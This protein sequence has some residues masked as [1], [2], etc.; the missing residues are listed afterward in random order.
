MFLSYRNFRLFITADDR[1]E[2]TMKVLA[3]GNKRRSAP[4]GG[5][6]GFPEDYR[7][8]LTSLPDRANT[9]PSTGVNVA[10]YV[11]PAR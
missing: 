6:T 5:F 10:R 8:I 3:S 2:R 7:N 4:P 9:F 1:R 11:A